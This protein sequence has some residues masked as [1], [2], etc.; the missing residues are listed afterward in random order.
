MV[1]T[2]A[3]VVVADAIVKN[4]PGFDRNLAFQAL[5]KDVSY[6]CLVSFFLKENSVLI[7][8]LGILFLLINLRLLKVLL[9]MV[10]LAKKVSTNILGWA[11][12]QRKVV[13]KS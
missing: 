1:G 7:I 8:L 11:I 6:F 2:F 9:A 12:C 13:E 3:D 4:V 5:S 10:E